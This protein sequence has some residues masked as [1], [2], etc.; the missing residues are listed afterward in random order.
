[1]KRIIIC[2]TVLIAIL[3][4]TFGVI[5]KN[6]SKQEGLVE[7]LV[8]D[9]QEDTIVVNTLDDNQPVI[10][11]DESPQESILLPYGEEKGYQVLTANTP[12]GLHT[13]NAF[14]F[15]LSLLDGWGSFDMGQPDQGQPLASYEILS[16]D[17]LVWMN[18]IASDDFTEIPEGADIDK[19]S[20]VDFYDLEGL[21]GY[22]LNS[23][24]GS[25]FSN[26]EIINVQLVDE[27]F[28]TQAYFFE[29]SFTN[30]KEPGKMKIY[31]FWYNQKL[32]MLQVTGSVAGHQKHDQDINAFLD[33]FQIIK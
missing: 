12:S 31:Q 22:H 33:G 8:V 2:L 14:N 19:V 6:K 30:N 21:V 28:G 4:I 11:G 23:T 25:R 3:A 15:Q 16:S 7:N 18:V 29:Y 32:Y 13:N 24:V 27:G 10:G 20:I 17:Q 5:L 1:M 9:T 26:P